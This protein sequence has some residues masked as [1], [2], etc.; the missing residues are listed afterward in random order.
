M[1]A[2]VHPYALA[3][4]VEQ[5]DG[6]ESDTGRTF[7]YTMPALVVRDQGYQPV[8]LGSLPPWATSCIPPIVSF[9]GLIVGTGHS[10]LRRDLL[11][12]PGAA[13]LNCC[14]FVRL[15][16]YVAPGMP[17]KVP[18]KGFH[19]FQV[20]VIFPVRANPGPSCARSLA[21]SV[22]MSCSTPG[23][24]RDNVFIVVPDSWTFLDKAAAA[25]TTMAPLLSTPQRQQASSASAAFRDVRAASLPR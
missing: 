24:D 18:F 7:L 3:W 23:S 17:N 25:V 6:L 1:H 15:S 10:S 21:C 13:Q 11:P 4:E 8:L 2:R 22:M 20:F 12:G 9:T 5:R 19:P 16:T 14:G